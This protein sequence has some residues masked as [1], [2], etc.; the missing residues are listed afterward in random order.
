MDK[1]YDSNNQVIQPEISR[2]RANSWPD[3][4]S[5]N[6][7]NDWH[8][9]KPQAKKKAINYVS[10]SEIIPCTFCA[11]EDHNRLACGKFAEWKQKKK[12]QGLWDESRAPKQGNAEDVPPVEEVNFS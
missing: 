2:K 8:S 12:N 5:W 6:S 7:N 10:R 1:C 11:G 9:R 4:S 3:V